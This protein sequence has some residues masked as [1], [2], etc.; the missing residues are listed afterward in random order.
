[1]TLKIY[2]AKDTKKREWPPNTPHEAEACEW[3]L[4]KAWLGF[5]HLPE[6]FA[7]IVN[8]NDPSADMLV[9]RE[10]GLGVL[11]M[12]HHSGQ[13]T[14]DKGG[15]WWAENR[16]IHSGN[17]RNPRE[18]VRSY[19][20]QIRGKIIRELLPARMKEARETWKELKFQ[21]GVCFTN[22]LANIR[23]L[24]RSLDQK[25][26]KLEAWE[27]NFSVI[28]I[29]FFTRWM[30]KLR[31]ELSE[32][33][34]SDY[35]PMRLEPEKIIKIAT[36]VLGAVEWEEMIAAMPKGHPW[37]HLILKEGAGREI[38]NLV[39]DHSTVGR[40]HLCDVVVPSRY[41][42]V[43]KHHIIIDRDVNGASITDRDSLNGTFIN[44]QLLERQKTYILEDGSVISLG[45]PSTGGKA[46]VLTFEI[47]GTQ[48]DETTITEQG[49]Q[50][51]EKVI[52]G[53]R[54]Q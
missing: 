48:S 51:L 27:D 13:I 53:K 25:P 44:D 10:L 3:M 40:S 22:P 12:K 2:V 9:I 1:M 30:R 8:L 50:E 4:Q 14:V 45:G 32:N 41:S 19:A 39:K 42:R 33:P 17:R 38:F 15:T 6:M 11:E 54:S 31:F 36:E 21:T 18:Q 47:H 5:H 16:R 26:P 28:D 35:A 23:E 49:T 29:N 52:T 20:R 24:K 7:V 46:C 43:S 34:P 37:S